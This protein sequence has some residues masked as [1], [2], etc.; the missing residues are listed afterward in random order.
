[1]ATRPFRDFA[2]R[3]T[4][5]DRIALTVAVLYGLVWVA[6]IAGY[7]P[8]LAFPIAFFF[9][10]SL[11]Y[12]VFRVGGWARTRLL[13]SLQNR[14]YIAYVFIAV[15]PLLMLLIMI[16][17]SARILYSQLGGYLL[18]EDLQKRVEEV[19]DAADT[20]ASAAAMFP[21]DADKAGT[22]KANQL[23]PE[24][25]AHVATLAADLPELE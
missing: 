11:G 3:L 15:V 5:I 8:R 14:L 20:V 10:L 6:R 24:L 25:E 16:V 23:P 19:S 1:M 17:L 21:P 12:L 9:F 7:E 22:R 13:W 2:R 4:L 18:V